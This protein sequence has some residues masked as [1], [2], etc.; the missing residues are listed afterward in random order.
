MEEGRLEKKGREIS[1]GFIEWALE[2][3]ESGLGDCVSLHPGPYPP[4]NF[5]TFPPPPN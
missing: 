3:I 2:T 5:N 4:P 1:E